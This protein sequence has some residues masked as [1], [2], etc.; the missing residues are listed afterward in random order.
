LLLIPF[1][2]LLANV[3]EA[4]PDQN[5]SVADV[6]RIYQQKGIMDQL[7][8]F[9]TSIK[10]RLIFPLSWLSGNYKDFDEWK[11]IVKKTVRDL[12]LAEPPSAPF[13]P[14][15][16]EQ[17][18]RGNYSARKIVFNVTADSR[19]LAYLL[20]PKGR[21]PFPA[22]LL[23]HDHG[24]KFDIGKEKV[25][26]PFHV[27]H[28]VIESADAWSQKIYAG[29][30]IGDE[31][32]G[33]GY[34]CLATD[35]LNWSDRGGVGYEGQQALAANLFNLGMS[36][37]GLIAYEDLNAAHFLVSLPE[38]DPCCIAAVGVSMGAYRA[39]QL[40]AISDDIQSAV[41]ICRMASIKELMISGN[42]LT[43]GQSAYT[44]TH[45]GLVNLLDLPDYASL[46]C[47][48]P[49]LFY[50]GENDYLFPV[51]AVKPAYEKMQMVWRSQNAAD[52]LVTKFWPVAHEF[53]AE[54]QAEAFAW[55]DVQLNVKA[56]KTIK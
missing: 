12:F 47:P 34:V 13:N 14:V 25:I 43:K 49:M 44:T 6:S 45:P 29:K 15:I 4:L 41:C 2:F 38:V 33:R 7:P 26:Q 23:L 39:W 55:L 37:A 48:K 50:S 8:E 32:A 40:A 24:A 42:N 54:M 19:I 31:L 18:D 21:G 53:T 46:A 17:E 3:I 20:V 56:S 11:S 27:E 52:K 35:A 10:E 5:K 36:Y 1:G 28:K 16:I 9:L 51:A 30:Y 22:V